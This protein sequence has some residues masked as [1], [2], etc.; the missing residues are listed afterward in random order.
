MGAAVA[1]LSN[2]DADRWDADVYG[3]IALASRLSTLV[4]SRAATI[5]LAYHFWQLDSALR[6]FLDEVYGVMESGTPSSGEEEKI[7]PER[8]EEAADTL[9]RLHKTVDS[10]YHAAKRAG[11]VNNSITAMAL[12]S[13]R[14]H[15]EDILELAD[16]FEMSLN[17]EAVES[18]FQRAS[19]EE[20]RGEIFDFESI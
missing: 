19:D 20:A 8:I 5:K 17:P 3:A 2:F 7:T 11:L 14:K 16:W 4:K 12:N 15:A 10:I 1:V 18:I 13:A 6:G 9:R